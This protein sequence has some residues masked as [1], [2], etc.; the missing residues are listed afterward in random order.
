MR[1]LALVAAALLMTAPAM[2][3]PSQKM[4][5]AVEAGFS[6]KEWNAAI[7]ECLANPD[8][9]SWS[10]WYGSPWNYLMVGCATHADGEVH[11]LY[12][13]HLGKEAPA[14]QYEMCHM[15]D[16]H[17]LERCVTPAGQKTCHKELPNA[18]GAREHVPCLTTGDEDTAASRAETL[19]SPN[20]LPPPTHRSL[21][22]QLFG[23]RR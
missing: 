10:Q 15:A 14:T 18:N 23:M 8:H 11:A 5:S 3:D 13:F 4:D 19:P 7:D 6:A 9:H 17:T 1:K 16:G 2:A 12:T 22:E 20:H 21:F